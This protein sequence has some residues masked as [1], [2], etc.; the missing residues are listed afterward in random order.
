MYEKVNEFRSLANDQLLVLILLL[1]YG[2]DAV[3][4]FPDR[5]KYLVNLNLTQIYFLIST[6]GFFQ[7]L[8][9]AQGV[10]LL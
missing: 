8:S 2:F 4:W 9:V 3:V 7:D 1:C 10:L 5:S 6:N